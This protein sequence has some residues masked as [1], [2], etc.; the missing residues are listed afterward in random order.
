M[1]DQELKANLGS[2]GTAETPRYLF[3]GGAPGLKVGDKVLP[4]TETGAKS[5]TLAASLGLGFGKIARSS[6]TRFT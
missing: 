6:S 2:P 3:H 4:P 5:Q 1:S